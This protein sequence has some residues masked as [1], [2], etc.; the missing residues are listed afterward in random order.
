MGKERSGCESKD[1][2]G[3]GQVYL[4]LV[5]MMICSKLLYILYFCRWSSTIRLLKRPVNISLVSSMTC[6]K[7]QARTNTVSQTVAIPRTQ[8]SAIT[9]CISRSN[10]VRGWS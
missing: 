2:K 7:T 8:S 6:K 1:T 9:A 3:L 10:S 4:V 5:L